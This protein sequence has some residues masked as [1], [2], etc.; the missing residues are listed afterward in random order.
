MNQY[1]QE[2]RETFQHAPQQGRIT[3]RL[4]DEIGDRQ[5]P[6]PVQIDGDAE[7]LEQS[8]GALACWHVAWT[9]ITYLLPA[10]KIFGGLPTGL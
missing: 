10:N 4:M 3:P 5:K 7:K 8:D 1:D 2:Q 6:R 9:Y